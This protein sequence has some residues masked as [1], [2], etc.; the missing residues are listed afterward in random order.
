MPGTPR[1]ARFV[2]VLPNEYG[3]A[4]R[5]MYAKAQSAKPAGAKAQKQAA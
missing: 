4:L 3:R 1:A 2:K 5:E